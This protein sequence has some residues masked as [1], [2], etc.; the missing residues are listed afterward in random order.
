VD[1]LGRAAIVEAEWALF[2]G[3]LGSPTVLAGALAALLTGAIGL[4]VGVLAIRRSA[5]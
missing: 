3:E 1:L 5:D 2:A 4:S